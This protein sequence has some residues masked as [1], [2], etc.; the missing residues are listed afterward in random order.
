MQGIIASFILPYSLPNPAL[1]TATVLRIKTLADN[2][3][4]ITATV[5]RIK[6]LADN[7]KG[8]QDPL[9]VKVVAY[10][11]NQTFKSSRANLVV[12]EPRSQ[13]RSQLGPSTCTVV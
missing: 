5:L 13:T 2:P 4:L 10:R 12:R 9:K 11:R 7:L 6:P 3:A 8:H 1:I